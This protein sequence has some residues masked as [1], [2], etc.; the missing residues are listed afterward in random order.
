MIKFWRYV[1]FAPV[2]LIVDQLFKNWAYHSLRGQTNFFVFGRFFA[3]EFYANPGIAFGIALPPWLFYLAFGMIICV[4]AYLAWHYFT[5]KQATAL[6]ALSFVFTGALS[7]LID[8]LRL[9][10]VI[11]Y[12]NLAFWPVF[13]LADVLIVAGVAVLLWQAFQAS[14][15]PQSSRPKA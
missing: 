4:I 10:Y 13:N 15:P 7:N 6:L 3:L 1:G 11:D 9:G 14:R 8:R 5:Q 2:L 12:L